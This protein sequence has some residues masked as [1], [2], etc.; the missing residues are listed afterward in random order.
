MHC[1]MTGCKKLASYDCKL[2]RESTN[3]SHFERTPFCSVAHMPNVIFLL[4]DFVEQVQPSSITYTKDDF[5]AEI[6]RL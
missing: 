5:K 4:H 6:N 2:S 1:Y 3:A